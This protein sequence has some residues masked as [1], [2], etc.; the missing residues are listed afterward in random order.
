MI[1]DGAPVYGVGMQGHFWTSMPSY[2][3]LKR[4]IN[5]VKALGLPMSVTEFDMVG[6]KYSDMER[7]LYAVYSEPQI[8]GFTIWDNR[9]GHYF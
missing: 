1:A 4:R 6:D 5:R 7:V 8:Y 9:R 2:E 3:E